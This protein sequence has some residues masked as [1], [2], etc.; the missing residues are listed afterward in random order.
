MFNILVDSQG[1]VI[2][3]L[4]AAWTAAATTM[5]AACW[6]ADVENLAP[7]YFG[8]FAPEL[9]ATPV[10]QGN[11]PPARRTVSDH[12]LTGPLPASE[13]QADLRSVMREIDSRTHNHAAKLP[14]PAAQERRGR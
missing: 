11:M 7:N 1:P 10:R 12:L 14:L 9:Q 4:A 13:K 3:R 2:I 5:P 8:Q 6:S